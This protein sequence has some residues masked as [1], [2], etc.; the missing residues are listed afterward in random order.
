MRIYRDEL[1]TCGDRFGAAAAMAARLPDLS[2][3]AWRDLIIDRVVYADN[4][5]SRDAEARGGAA[6]AG[7]LAEAAREDLR[8]LQRLADDAPDGVGPAWG[9][10]TSPEVATTLATSR[11]WAGCLPLLANHHHARGCGDFARYGAFRWQRGVLEPVTAPDLVQVLIGYERERGALASNT[12]RFLRGLPAH[13]VLLYGARGTGKSSSVKALLTVYRCRGLR[14]IEAGRGVFGDFSAL[15]AAVRGRRQRFILFL[16]D[17]SFEPAE[18]EYKALKAALEGG[19][20]ARPDNLLVVATSNRRHLVHE[21]FA[22]RED[23]HGE[24]TIEEK[25]SLADRFGLTL[26]FATP[27]EEAYLQI[28]ERLCRARGLHIEEAELRER[29]VRWAAWGSGRSGRS[30][31]QLVDEL[32]AEAGLT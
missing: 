20:Q 11:D 22:E 29:A 4:P 14:L 3:S 27:D 6:C 16:D 13:D 28:V 12:E 19:V 1:F 8:D 21:G 9:S 25:A 32:A 2:G 24:D 23:L 7:W 18:T 30:A 31:R 26:R 17:L 10:G 5:W 15:A